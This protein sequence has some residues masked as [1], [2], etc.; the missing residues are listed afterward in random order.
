MELCEWYTGG[1]GVSPGASAPFK[2]QVSGSSASPITVTVSGSPSGVS[3]RFTYCPAPPKGTKNTAT[4]CT[5]SSL[6]GTQTF[7]AALDVPSS[8]SNGE[9]VTLTAKASSG[10]TAI[11]STSAGTTVVKSAPAGNGGGGAQQPG[12]GGGSRTS[13]GSSNGGSSPGSN[14]TTGSNTSYGGGSQL[15]SGAGAPSPAAV[16]AGTGDPLAFTAGPLRKFLP[17]IN[18]GSPTRG[19]G[20]VGTQL[21][22]IPPAPDLPTAKPAAYHGTASGPL[23]RQMLGTQLL[24][25]AA[26]CAAVGIV[27][28]RFWRRKPNPALAQGAAATAAGAVAG[29]GAGTATVPVPGTGPGGGRGGWRRFLPWRTTGTS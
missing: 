23:S 3:A 4:S 20:N 2:I 5:V 1:S 8:A 27:L 22:S 12:G 9:A 13:P 17:L 6:N 29:T 26:L 14:G 21:P 25:L 10:S 11:A 19:N 24:G 16:A 15:G 18:G 28:I 7:L